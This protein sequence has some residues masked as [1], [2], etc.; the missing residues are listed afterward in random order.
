MVLLKMEFVFLILISF[1]VVVRF[2]WE[3]C[4]RSAAVKP[5]TWPLTRH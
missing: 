1:G 4:Q 5:R 2:S 3:K